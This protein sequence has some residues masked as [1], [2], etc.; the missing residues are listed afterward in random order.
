MFQKKNSDKP[1]IQE[2]ISPFNADFGWVFQ[3]ICQTRGLVKR[4]QG[5]S[6]QNSLWPL[7]PGFGARLTRI[8]PLLPNIDKKKAREAQRLFPRDYS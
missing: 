7:T 3:K 2:T 1:E 5:Y 8:R 4:L 6:R